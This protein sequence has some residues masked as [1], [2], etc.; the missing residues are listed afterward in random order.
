MHR[1]C[2]QHDIR[3]Y[4]PTYRHLR[5]NL[6]KQA[7]A[8]VELAELRARAEAGELL[9][10]SQDEAR[11]SMV[12]TLTATPG[13]KG[14]PPTAG[15]RDCKDL[16]YVLA[17]IDVITAAVH[18][19]LVESPASLGSSTASGPASDPAY[20]S[21]ARGKRSGSLRCTFTKVYK[22]ERKTRNRA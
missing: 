16:L 6:V 18:A 2:R 15:T 9:L 19:N 5:G 4:R 22:I 21:P 11:F 1:F 17:V 20:P 7:V 12:P 10:L 8:A 3:P 14:H 13:V